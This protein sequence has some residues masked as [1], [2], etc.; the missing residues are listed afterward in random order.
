MKQIYIYVCICVYRYIGIQV[1]SSV[2]LCIRI[3]E[4]IKQIKING[5]ILLYVFMCL[6]TWLYMCIQLYMKT[7]I[8]NNMYGFIYNKMCRY[9]CDYLYLCITNIIVQRTSDKR[10][11][12]VRKNVRRPS[13]KRATTVRQ[14]CDGRQTILFKM[15]RKKVHREKYI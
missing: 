10:A 7:C 4:K 3:N 1:Y 13:D 2:C 12:A 5:Y 14:A 11:T 9:I 6:C 8:L 15:I